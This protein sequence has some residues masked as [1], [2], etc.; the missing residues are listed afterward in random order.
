MATDLPSAQ[1]MMAFWFP[2]LALLTSHSYGSTVILLLLVLC[3]TFIHL[4]PAV[5]SYLPEEGTES[6]ENAKDI[7]HLSPVRLHQTKAF[8]VVLKLMVALGGWS[9]KKLLYPSHRWEH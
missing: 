5:T 3:R 6:L 1:Y 8:H 2:T 4:S 7:G 9:G